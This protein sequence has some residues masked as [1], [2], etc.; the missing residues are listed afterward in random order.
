MYVRIATIKGCWLIYGRTRPALPAA[1]FCIPDRRNNAEHERNVGTD[2]NAIIKIEDVICPSPLFDCNGI[3]ST[4]KYRPD[5]MSTDHQRYSIQ[6]Q[7]TTTALKKKPPDCSNVADAGKNG[8]FDSTR[9]Y[10]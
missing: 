5:R 8:S 7:A 1:A 6:N 3:H 4:S 9:T 2:R 10:A